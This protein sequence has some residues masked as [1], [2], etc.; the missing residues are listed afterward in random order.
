MPVHARTSYSESPILL[1]LISITK[2]IPWG[3]VASKLFFIKQMRSDSKEK[4]AGPKAGVNPSWN[5]ETA[6]KRKNYI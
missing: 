4:F 1:P 6:A 5:Q 3:Q 2:V